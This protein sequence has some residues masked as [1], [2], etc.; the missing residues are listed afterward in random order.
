MLIC[1]A[2]VS[3]LFLQSSWRKPRGIDNRARRR[4]KGATL[5]PK[6]GY[7]TNAKTRNLMPNGFFKA[8]VNNVKEL[9]ALMMQNR[10]C[11]V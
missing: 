2:V 1:Y 8:V 11:V 7:G 10:R 5:M 9:E 4:Y 3:F 6:I